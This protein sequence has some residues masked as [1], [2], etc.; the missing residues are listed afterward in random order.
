MRLL[1]ITQKIDDNDD[2]LGFFHAWIVEFAR[3]CERVT[4]VGLSVGAHNFPKNVCVFSLGKETGVSRCKYAGNFYRLIIRERKNYDAVFVHM[5]PEYVL[6]GGILW[7]MMGKKIGLWYTHK[8]VDWRLRLAACAADIIFTASPESFRLK[9][10]KCHVVGHG[11]DMGRFQGI[12]RISGRE[13]TFRILSIGRLT[14]AKNY[15]VLLDAL[16][17]LS[18]EKT[19]IETQ[20]VGGPI[21]EED[22]R[23]A[24]ELR[25]EIFRR[26]LSGK[27]E[28]VGAVPHGAIEPYLRKVD[29]FVNMST[30]GSLDK[31]ALEAMAA[32]VPVLTSN[33]GLQTTLA[34]FE[35]SCMFVAGDA[36]DF[37]AHIR[38]LMRMS[39]AER[40]ALGTRLR[41]V[42]E[43]SHNLTTLIPRVLGCY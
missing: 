37:A 4:V 8:H 13:G 28:L 29:L 2:V 40:N 36:K 18:D 15:G 19:V 39:E 33:E 41:G 17:R 30:T 14:Q 10:A 20:I 7:K 9:T 22:M 5:N 32:G 38:A 34:G 6:L 12:E 16:E 3:Y 21:T 31:A 1:I 23:Y 43:R 27:V 26:G 35:N 42:V 24:T 25:T 11:I